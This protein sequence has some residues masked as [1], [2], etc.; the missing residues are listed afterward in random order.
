M[1]VDGGR[2][3]QIGRRWV[4]VGSGGNVTGQLE[5]LERIRWEISGQALGAFLWSAG[6]LRERW[7]ESNVGVRKRGRETV[8]IAPKNRIRQPSD[9]CT[10]LA[11]LGPGLGRSL[12]EGNGTHKNNSN[13]CSRCLS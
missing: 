6:E 4:F 2:E 5:W 8:C 1:G 3:G 10:R 9:H 13:C 12:L 7:I 11:G